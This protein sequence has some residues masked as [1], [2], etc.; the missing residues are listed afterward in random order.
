MEFI[1]LLLVL[2]GVMYLL[3]ILFFKETLRKS[4]F[5]DYLRGKRASENI[6]E[7]TYYEQVATE[8]R[9]GRRHEG[10]W[11]KACAEAS[12]NIEAVESL[13][14]KLRVAAMK[15]DVSDKIVKNT[16]AIIS[17]T[18]CKT[19]LR[20]PVGKL[21]EVRC[22]KCTHE[23]FVDSRW[24][25]KVKEFYIPSDFLIGRMGRL[26]YIFLYLLACIM[27]GVFASLSRPGG[28]DIYLF[29]SLGAILSTV[30]LSLARIRDIG[31]STWNLFYC[32]IPGLCF[33]FAIYLAIKPGTPG[34]NQYGM[35]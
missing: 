30:A 21:L 15:K 7:E 20:I 8:L 2:A 4:G 18:Q 23:M 33:L 25:I 22:P 13:Y 16:T 10:I 26:K 5:F 17:C 29:L 12:G 19:N 24:E 6:P 3:Y 35:P 34:R 32:F 9:Q 11:L 28:Q 27:S 14:I 31:I 1:F